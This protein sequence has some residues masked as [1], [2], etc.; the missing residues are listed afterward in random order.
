MR[1]KGSACGCGIHADPRSII[2]NELPLV[3]DSDKRGSWGEIK[4]SYFPVNIVYTSIMLPLI[5]LKLTVE[6]LRILSL[7]PH[8][9]CV[10]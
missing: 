3:T 1:N 2:L 7:F 5:L 10:L 8:M 6:R 9:I 4:E